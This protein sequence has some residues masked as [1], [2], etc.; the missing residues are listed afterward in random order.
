[1]DRRV[2]W[3][4][5]GSRGPVY[6]ARPTAGKSFRIVCRIRSRASAEISMAAHRATAMRTISTLWEMAYQHRLRTSF[7]GGRI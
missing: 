1:V 7:L 2:V 3:D 5:Y 4:H 6:M